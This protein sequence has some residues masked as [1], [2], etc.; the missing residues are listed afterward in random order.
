[1]KKT[2]FLNRM[3]SAVMV[4]AMLLTLLPG[5]AL[6]EGTEVG[7]GT[8]AG[9]EETG[10]AGSPAATESIAVTYVRTTKSGVNLRESAE[11]KA[12]SLNEKNQ[13]GL[14][15]VF[16]CY[17][18]VHNDNYDW[19]LIVYDGKSGYIRGD[20]FMYCDVEGNFLVT[21]SPTPAGGVTPDVNATGYVKA[22]RSSLALYVVPEGEVLNASDLIPANQVMPYYAGPYV[23]NGVNWLRVSY[24]NM[25][26]YIRE[27]DATYCDYNGNV[28]A[29]AAPETGSVIGYVKLTQDKV[30]L[31]ATPGGETLNDKDLMPLGKVLPY[32]L[33]PITEKGYTWVRVIYNG[34]T[35][36]VRKDCFIYCD[37]TGLYTTDAPVDN[38]KVPSLTPT[39][40][41]A[42]ETQ[43]GYVKVNTDK[44]ILRDKPNGVQINKN[45]LIPKD[46]IMPYTATPTRAGG[47]DWLRVIYVSTAGGTQTGYVR[48]DYVDYCDAYGNLILTTSTP[49]VAPTVQPTSSVLE[50]NWGR[51]TADKVY[52]RKEAST[53]SGYWAKL[54]SGWLMEIL[55]TELRGS[56]TWYKVRGGTPANSSN[57]YT[58]YIHGDYFKP[59][60]AQPT[61]TSSASYSTGYAMVQLNGLNLRKTPGGDSI[62]TLN[63]GTIVN[64]IYTAQNS[65]IYDW[66]YVEYKGSYGYLQAAYLWVLTDDDVRNGSFILPSTPAPT[67]T[68]SPTPAYTGTGYILVVKDKVNIRKTPNGTTLTGRDAD[69][70]RIGTVLAY[71]EGPTDKI[72]G[73]YWVKVTSGTITGYVRS[74][75]Y[76]YCDQYGVPQLNTA[77]PTPVPGTTSVPTGTS[78]V[79]TKMGGVNLRNMPEGASQL[80]LDKGLVL[81]SYGTETVNN[82]VWY[83]V[84]YEKEGLY[85]YLLSSMVY[86][87]DVNGNAITVTPAPTG[88]ATGYVATSKSGVWVRTAPA[89]D[90]GTAGQVKDKGTVVTVTGSSIR[91]GVYTW[92]PVILSDGTR[93]Y[94]RG[95]CVFEIAQWQLDIYKSTGVC[96]TP[97]PGPATP[98]PGNSSFI[99]TVADKL[100]VRKTP[101]K[102]ASSLGQL[103]IGTVTEFYSKK[104]VGTVTW[105]EVKLGS[106]YG[107]VHGDYV[108]V[109]TNAEYYDYLNQNATPS[110]TPAATPDASNLS[111]LA[112][113]TDKSVNI[114]ASAS[115]SG[116]SLIKVSKSGTEMT[117]LGNYV[118]PTT[119]NNYYW[120]NVRY[121]GVSG[122]MRGDFVRVLTTA[123]KTA[124]QQTGNPDGDK[125]AS[126]TVLKKNS[127]GEAVTNLQKKL[128]EKGYLFSNSDVTGLYDTNTENAVM[129]FQRQNSLSVTGIADENTQHALFGTIPSGSGSGSSTDA[130]LYPVEIVDWYTGDIQSIWR[131][132]TVAV[133]TDVYTGLS[134]KAQRLYGDNHADCEPLTTADTA[135]YCQIF[136]VS[137]PQEISD[138]EKDLQSWRRRPLWVTVGGRT[139]CASLYGIPH[140][141]KGDKIP[142]NDFNG[143]FCVHFK[144]SRTHNSNKVDTASSA[145][146]YFGHQEAIQ[147][148]YEHSKSGT[149]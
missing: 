122:W 79:C 8:T 42:P 10:G 40:T 85:G 80:Q 120:Y 5:A 136:G 109:L 60:E 128:L 76:S 16:F 59:V 137:D 139:F 45:N 147:Y 113:T 70:L 47:Y 149:K 35:G 142:D 143:Q 89:A 91:N 88:T 9:T 22:Q 107:Y 103:S 148:A 102:Q 81:R 144:N 36:Y 94:L 30:Y 90:A 125:T 96:P 31:R 57:T 112:L 83:R 15:E 53:S 129:N 130:T 116:K 138:Y 41:P 37:S 48:T 145:N 98:P 101:S 92:Y 24:H 64:V 87:C 25:N 39:P 14:G 95:D 32:T 110:P 61:V 86:E 19:A 44:L 111:D 140:N 132:G 78:Y 17:Q 77:T 134:F 51:T 93:G 73:Y 74:D 75:C 141:Y 63:S 43:L 97:T 56:V 55:S 13:I 118:A 108:Q 50:G 135:V 12:K 38:D 127:T 123:E 146:G 106:S 21:P 71:S 1:M 33:G 34:M 72:G 52:F 29:T 28:L 62:T 100:Y 2:G 54:P 126:Y 84:Y 82:Q 20:C 46:V 49:T 131:A 99:R 26:G 11:T 6:G 4:A 65:S 18:V 121:N 67:V 114:R 3:I 68:P 105:Y 7:G 27:S 104:I 23:V 69:K 117:Y 124:Y 133:I 58:G 115:M 119:D 66:Y